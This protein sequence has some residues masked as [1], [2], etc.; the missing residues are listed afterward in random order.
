MQ[1]TDKIK[2]YSALNIRVSN[3]M[4]E[5]NLTIARLAE[6]SGIAIGTI[7]KMMTDPASNPTLSS[8]GAIAKALGVSVCSLIGHEDD[9]L[10]KIVTVPLFTLQEIV[11]AWNPFEKAKERKLSI[12]EVAKTTCK[13]S[14]KSFAVILAGDYMMPAFPEN[15]LLIF[16]PEKKY[17]NNSFVLVLIESL[18]EVVF[19]KLMIN[20]DK[21]YCSPLNLAY[22]DVRLL[23]DE[24]KIIATLSQSQMQY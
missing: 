15:T 22:G 2:N 4:L 16:D 19:N 10:S 24:D 21:F 17:Y 7:Q 14:S 8:I 11:H 12:G 18:T 23:Q 20:E 3:L 5:N 9:P 6:K 1:T 13:V